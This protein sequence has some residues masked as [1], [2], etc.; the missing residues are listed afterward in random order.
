MDADGAYDTGMEDTSGDYIDEGSG[1][2]MMEEDIV[3]A[4]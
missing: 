1:D 3:I 2:E 4:D